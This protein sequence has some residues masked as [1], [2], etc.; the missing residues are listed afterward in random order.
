M[1]SMRRVETRERRRRF[2]TRSRRTWRRRRT[3]R[4]FRTNLRMRTRKVT[5]MSGRNRRMTWR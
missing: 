5:K 3:R 4:R 2:F 1:M